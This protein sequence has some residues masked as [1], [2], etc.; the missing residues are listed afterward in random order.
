[1]TSTDGTGQPVRSYQDL[2]DHLA[3]LTR[4]TSHLG[5]ATFD[6]ISEPTPHTTAR[7]ELLGVPIPLTL[8]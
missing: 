2:R 1:M 7:I 3:T 4:N 5:S 8:A 6:Q